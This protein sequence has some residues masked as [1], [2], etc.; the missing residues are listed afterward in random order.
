[1]VMKLTQALT[2]MSTRN[3]PEGKGWP[4]HETDNLTTIHEPVVWIMWY[5]Q[6]PTTLWTS[7]AFYR[8]SFTFLLTTVKT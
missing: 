5:P 4:V 3:L 8:D 6:H 2:E 1:M 7:M